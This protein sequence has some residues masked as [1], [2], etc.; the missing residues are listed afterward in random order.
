MYP[1]KKMTNVR[2]LI[3]LSLTSLNPKFDP[4]NSDFHLAYNQGASQF[5]QIRIFTTKVIHFIIDP[6]H[7]SYD[8]RISR[9]H[10]LEP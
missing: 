9:D 6:T 5:A 7:N 3:I 2:T 1:A 8:K 4:K 10:I